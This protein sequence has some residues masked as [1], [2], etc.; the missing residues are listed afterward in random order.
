MAFDHQLFRQQF[1]YFQHNE[2]AVYFDNAATTL[3]PQ[4]LI[5]STVAFYQSAGS[6]HRSQYDEN[7][8]ALYEQ[9]RARVKALI[10]AESEDAVIW[11]SGTTQAVN[12]VANGLLAQL[13]ADDEII[14]SEA[15]HH[16]NFVTW[17]QIAKKCG[18]K[19]IVLPITDQWLIDEQALQQALNERTK[20]VALNFVSNV[21]GTEQPVEK[22]IKLI[23]KKTRAFVLVDAAQA[24]SHLNID[25]Q[26][27]DA[28]FIAFSA[29]KIYGP[30][31]LGVLSGKL[32]ALEQ[33]QPLIFGGKMVD[34]V[35]KSHISF[36]PLPYRLEAGTPNIAAVIGFS[37]VLHWLENWDIE[38]AESYVRQLTEQI[39]VRL[40]NYPNCQLFESPQPSSVIS[41]VFKHIASSDLATL[42]TEQGI[43]LRTGEH[44]AQP[45]LA[46]LGESSTLR[47]SLAP[48]NNTEEIDAFFNA[49]N[50]ALNL[51]E[52]E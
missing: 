11:T 14:I 52:I 32:S 2:N 9:A 42:L 4:V 34:R 22:L 3:K 7:Q 12:I 23:R 38:Q 1:P 10:N 16:A 5:D 8:T 45:Y 44:C 20:L 17:Q 27:L 37:A 51:L 46:R 25:I 47:L 13:S 30:N 41:F 49:L 50:N 29:H 31:G 39:K 48:Y 40:K 15:D 18:A 21:T 35:S 33:L 26:R 24:I 43:A 6:V 28:D 19:I 36:A